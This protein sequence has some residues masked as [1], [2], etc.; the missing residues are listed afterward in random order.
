[1][2][3]Y[4]IINAFQESGIWPVS[5]A[6][7]IKKMRSYSK[8]RKVPNND[9]DSDDDDDDDA[10]LPSLP[11]GPNSIYQ[12]EMKITEILDKEPPTNWSSPS[13]S[14]FKETLTEARVELNKSHL[15]SYEH[16]AQQT[17]LYEEQKRR[18][19]S[20][21]KSNK[22]GECYVD[23][24]REK[25][26]AREQNEKN[27][28]IRKAEKAIT[29]Q[30]NKAKKELYTRGVAARKAEKARKVSVWELT[31]K[32]EL[33]PE[34]LTIPIRDPE[35]DPTK[36]EKEA[37][38]PHPSLVQALNELRPLDDIDLDSEEDEVDI[39]L[40]PMRGTVDVVQDDDTDDELRL[41]QLQ[42]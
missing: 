40:E 29:T 22:G 23:A 6:A 39:Q 26:A 21:R 20:R 12:T 3:Q 36:E 15:I 28:A 19:T 32:G 17:R 25:I 33:I 11:S 37:L 24:A 38:K 10:K 31:T 1:M 16:R 27:E 8:K 41:A 2:K 35:K 4:T 7:G 42:D 5:Y 9:N 13:K 14:K 34:E 30:V 18:S